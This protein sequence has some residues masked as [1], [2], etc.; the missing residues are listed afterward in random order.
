MPS[1]RTCRHGL[2]ALPAPSTSTSTRR[3]S[4]PPVLKTS[5]LKLPAAT[6]WP[7]PAST[8][9]RYRPAG[10]VPTARSLARLSVPPSRLPC[11]AHDVLTTCYQSV[12]RTAAA[13]ALPAA[14]SRHAC[15]KSTMKLVADGGCSS[16]GH[17]LHRP[18]G[19]CRRTERRV[20]PRHLSS[21]CRS[22]PTSTATAQSSGLPGWF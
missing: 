11:R 20:V 1:G 10:K 6:P 2:G 16:G 17:G 8:H 19:P 18:D 21:S 4:L 12:P 13:A 22:S 9:R 3:S 15:R 14:A 7:R 5:T